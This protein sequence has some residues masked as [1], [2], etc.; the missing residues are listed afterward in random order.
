MTHASLK[1]WSVRFL[2]LSCAMLFGGCWWLSGRLIAPAK[3]SLRVPEQVLPPAEV[4][5]ITAANAVQ[6]WLS[7]ETIATELGGRCAAWYGANS[8]AAATIILAHPI[9]SNRLSMISRARFLYGL[10]YAVLLIDLQ[11]HGES[12][13]D[14]ITFGYR[15][16][17]DVSAAVQWVR[18]RSPNH[19]VAVIGRSLGGAAALLASPSGID[20]MVLESVY[21]TIEEA[22]HNR[23]QQRAGPLAHLISPMLLLQLPLRLGIAPSQ[24]RPIDSLPEANCPVLIMSG[25]LDEHTTQEETERMFAAAESPKELAIFPNAGHVDLHANDQDLYERR[26]SSFLREHLQSNSRAATETLHDGI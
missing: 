5:K 21:P 11:A 9:R 16:S 23:V 13:G 24:L 12:N 17:Y 22:T 1:K 25:G 18:Q 19:K 7:N 15:E 8:R 10:G 2:L 3:C 4:A 6:P 20:A 26:V 14:H